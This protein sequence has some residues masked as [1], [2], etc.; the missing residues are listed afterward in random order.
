MATTLTVASIFA[1]YICQIKICT[2]ETVISTTIF[3]NHKKIFKKLE[4]HTQQNYLSYV[5]IHNDLS[6]G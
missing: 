2:P 1:L 5:K 3:L 6:T 4:F